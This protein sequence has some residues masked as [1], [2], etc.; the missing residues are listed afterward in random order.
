[1]GLNTDDS[2]RR[3]KGPG[4][5]I[6][7][8]EDRALI[9]AALAAVDAVTLFGEDT[10]AEL[11]EALLPDVLAKGG[12]Y[13]MEDIVGR[14]AVVAAGGEVVVIPFVEGHSTTDLV[15]RIRGAR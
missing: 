15:Q 8:Q 13:R 11:I 1:M 10:P 4:R 3:L 9:V 12:D 6:L 7:G 5:P 14:R 2:V